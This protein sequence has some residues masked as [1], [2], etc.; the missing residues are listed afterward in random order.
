VS[1]RSTRHI[2]AVFAAAVTLGACSG[3]PQQA[4]LPSSPQT[5]NSAA[6][7]LSVTRRAHGVP[8]GCKPVVVDQTSNVVSFTY[9]AK[10]GAGSYTIVWNSPGGIIDTIVPFF[11]FYD[12]NQNRFDK[13]DNAEQNPTWVNKPTGWQGTDVQPDFWPAGT[14]EMQISLEGSL[15]PNAVHASVLVKCKGT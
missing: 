7:K 15:A 6:T 3:S 9:T 11:E 2:A 13:F 14:Y 1:P 5:L 10:A 4:S 12:S 8:A